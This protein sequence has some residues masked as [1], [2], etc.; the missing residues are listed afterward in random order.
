MSYSIYTKKPTRSATP[1]VRISSDGKIVLNAAAT[2]LFHASGTKLVNLLFD[3]KAGMIALRAN[4]NKN[5]SSYSLSYGRNNCQSAVFVKGFLLEIGWDGQT[6]R[7]IEARWDGRKSLLELSMPK[8]G[9]SG[10]GEV[11]P[12]E[13]KTG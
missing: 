2:R 5:K 3:L 10:T 13:Q 1:A 7:D 12:N 11:V 8:W 9:R 4:T 6:Y